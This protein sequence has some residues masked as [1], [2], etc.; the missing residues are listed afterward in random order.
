MERK[1]FD[2]ILYAAMVGTMPAEC[3]SLPDKAA[4][5]STAGVKGE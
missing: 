4:G 1:L 2:A 3:G 5:S